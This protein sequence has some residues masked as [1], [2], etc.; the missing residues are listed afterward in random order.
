MKE[1]L[2]TKGYNFYM[3]D[4]DQ[5]VFD[6]QSGDLFDGSFASVMIYATNRGFTINHLELGVEMM[7]SLNHDAIHFGMYQSPIYSF[8]RKEKKVA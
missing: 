8:N 2:N 5:W 3:M 1:Q 6:D 4:L 7:L